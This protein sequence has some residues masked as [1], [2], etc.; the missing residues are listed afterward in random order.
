MKRFVKTLAVAVAMG[1]LPLLPA[2]AAADPIPLILKIQFGKATTPIG[3]NGDKA[4]SLTFIL[5]NANPD[6]DIGSVAFTANLPAGLVVSDPPNPPGGDNSCN[7]GGTPGTLTANAGSGVVTYSGATIKAKSGET[8]GDCLITVFVR[9]TTA[10]HKTLS[11]RA[12]SDHGDSWIFVEPDQILDLPAEA[13]IDVLGP[14]TVTK[15]F[16]AGP[17]IVLNHTTALQFAVH[18]PNSL[19][20]AHVA[21]ADLLPEGLE[22]ATPPGVAGNLCGG[23]LV[24]TPVNPGDPPLL[25]KEGTIPAGGTCTFSVNVK[26]TIPGPVHNT[27]SVVF[28]EDGGEGTATSAADLTIVAPPVTVKQFPDDV[29]PADPTTPLNGMAV[30]VIAM[31]NTN[32]TVALTG[33]GFTDN[34]PLGMVVA[35]PPYPP[36]PSGTNTCNNGGTPGVV[37]AVP[38]SSQVLYSGATIAPGT[39][40]DY[41]NCV[42]I[43][44]VTGTT[45]GDKTNTV[46]ASANFTGPGDSS[47]ASILVVAPPTVTKT[48]ASAFNP[49]SLALNQSTT[50][51]FEVS[52]SNRVDLTS[53][54]FGDGLPEGLIVST[55]NGAAGNLCGGTLQADE[56]GSL[57]VLTDATVPAMSSCIF[58]VSITGTSAGTKVNETSETFSANGGNGPTYSATLYVVAPPV[59]AKQFGAEQV[60]HGDVTTLSFT[61]VNPPENT[62]PLTGVGFADLLPPGL[63]IAAP[64]GLTGSCFNGTIVAPAFTRNVSMTGASIPVDS[65]CTFTINVVGSGSSAAIEVQNVSGSATSANGG[66]GNVATASIRVVPRIIPTLQE[67]ALMLLG[68]LLAAT[69][70]AAQRRRARPH[71]R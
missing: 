4:V 29:H 61:I 9:G 67:W 13:S 59:I 28:F 35:E 3:A 22:V 51:T 5:A 43:V 36:I 12:S 24:T 52:N 68:L 56:G 55:P 34:L 60:I 41:S 54:G 17:Q 50:L 63:F 46:A 6:Y 44:F 31:V 42:V 19:P 48:F 38:G 32:P 10:G 27:T 21:F 49:P 70:V 14:P 25:Y 23:E 30:M 40:P 57:I 37:T 15:S 26:G 1:A 7:L 16:P 45:P 62:I 11:M 39:A 33:V 69:G 2:L 66:E 47:S 64:N 8:S 71:G 58:S 65:W 20:V 53:V 18:N